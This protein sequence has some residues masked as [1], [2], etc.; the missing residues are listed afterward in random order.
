MEALQALADLYKLTLFSPELCILLCEQ[1]LE[2]RCL[3]LHSRCLCL[4]SISCLHSFH[5]LLLVEAALIFNAPGLLGGLREPQHSLEKPQDARFMAASAA[6]VLAQD[7][8]DL[9]RCGT[10]PFQTAS[11]GAALCVTTS[12][13]AHGTSSHS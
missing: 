10:V 1:G 4:G 6:Y 7:G 8:R 12:D 13:N 5:G 2:A 9:L 11:E 3:L